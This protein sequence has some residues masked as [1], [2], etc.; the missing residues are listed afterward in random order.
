[1]A[2][3]CKQTL[4]QTLKNQGAIK[5][6]LKFFRKY[7]REKDGN[8]DQDEDKGDFEL[9]LDF[10]LDLQAGGGDIKKYFSTDPK[11]PKLTLT[12]AA[13][14]KLLVDDP[15]N[16]EYVRQAKEDVMFNL[17]KYHEDWILELY[18]QGTL[19]DHAG[20]TFF[21]GLNIQ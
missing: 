11:D 20:E 15:V 19:T 17:G 18:S 13:L 9:K 21:N 5:E 16:E 2:N 1:M 12:N 10:V 3:N 14:R 7:I 6:P 4:D 8:D